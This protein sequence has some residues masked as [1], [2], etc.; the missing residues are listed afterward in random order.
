LKQYILDESYN[1]EFGARP[2]KRFIQKHI[3]TFIATKM[4]QGEIKPSIPYVLDACNKEIRLL[5]Q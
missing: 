2:I 1:L 4:I 5:I 3:E